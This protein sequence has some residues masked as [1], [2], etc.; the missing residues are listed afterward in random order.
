[1]VQIK[2]IR[3]LII[4]IDAL[5][6]RNLGCY[7]YSEQTSP[8][9]DNLAR[10][11]VLF[12]DAYSCQ[13]TT[14]P[15]FTTIFSGKYP[16]SHGIIRHGQRV[17]KTDIA[18]LHASATRFL[19]EILKGEGYTTLAVDWLG[20]WH[21]RGYDYYSGFLHQATL[22]TF[23]VRKIESYL[24]V[25]SRR[26][27]RFETSTIID[28]ASLVTA[29]AKNLITRNCNNKFLLFIHYWDI[30]SPYAPP[31]KFY[32]NLSE[33]GL[34]KAI[35]KIIKRKRGTL[36]RWR[37]HENMMRY[38]ASIAYVDYEIGKLV[39]A[40]ETCGILDQT[41]I[42]LTS[43]HGESLG[44]HNISWD[45]HG[46]YDVSIHVPLIIRHPDL[47][48]NRRIKGFVQHFDIVPTTLDLLNMKNNDFDGKS[49]L[50]LIYG[51]TDQLHSAVY[52]EE[53][54]SQDKRAIRTSD[55]KYI[56]A[57]SKKG[58]VCRVCGY[59]HGGMEELYDLKEDPEENRNIVKEKSDVANMLKKRLTNWASRRVD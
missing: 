6:A 8:N 42:I 33:Q 25:M 49:V 19:P 26:Y 5:R 47:P 20:R 50:P 2:K 30:H 51:E 39:E 56:Q 14:D 40:L 44:E 32:E 22:R 35:K 24:N 4:G 34:D 9:I 13:N 31:T 28:N 27:A 7:G 59:I 45:H 37:R 17:R 43:D 12:E 11:G 41:L 58:A 55:F 48:R 15:S 53:A 57:L 29:Q 46:L 16:L 38:D 3:I 52:A 18:K 1:M 21:R 10:E 36:T 23:P 54:D